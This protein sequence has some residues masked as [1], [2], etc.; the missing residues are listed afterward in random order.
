MP[1]PGDKIEVYWPDDHQHY[2]G[3]VTE[4]KS[5]EYKFQINYD[6]GDEETLRLEDEIW[7]PIEPRD[8]VSS[9]EIQLPPGKELTSQ[10]KDA[11]EEYFRLF[12]S[13]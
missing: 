11:I 6:D 1:I 4:Y 13:K 12:Q 3:T 5:D 9:N 2:P 10:E 7:R 8:T